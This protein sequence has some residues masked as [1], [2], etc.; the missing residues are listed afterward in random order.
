MS[1]SALLCHAALLGCS[2]S[3]MGA[4]WCMQP[5]FVWWPPKGC[6]CCWC[7]WPV[8]LQNRRPFE[9]VEVS[10][11]W[12]TERVVLP[13]AYLTFGSAGFPGAASTAWEQMLHPLCR[14][15]CTAR[16][17]FAVCL[18]ELMCWWMP[19]TKPHR[20]TTGADGFGTGVC[21]RV[22][23]LKLL[24]RHF[25]TITTCRLHLA[26]VCPAVR[27]RV[28]LGL[29][30]CTTVTPTCR[31]GFCVMHHHFGAFVF[32]WRGMPGCLSGPVMMALIALT[33]YQVLA[34]MSTGGRSLVKC[35]LQVQA[36]IFTSQ[37]GRHRLSLTAGL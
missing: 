9:W 19:P 18:L 11:T 2:R 34:V 12:P 14:Q 22:V 5:C 16:L 27:D 25:C 4:A 35:I 10:T 6:A 28:A 8:S 21:T 17:V 20:C 37:S 29:V 24:G 15:Q 36:G 33:Y 3:R 1:C 26:I 7:W 23:I 32:L 31:P 13:D 30:S